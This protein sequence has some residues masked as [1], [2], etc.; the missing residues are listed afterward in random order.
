MNKMLLAAAAAT[1]MLASAAYAAVTF[2]AATGK[3]FVGK[4]DVQLALTMNNAQLQGAANSIALNDFAAVSTSSIDSEWICSKVNNAGFEQTQERSRSITT[5]REGLLA[6]VARERNQIT[7]FILTGYNGAP[8]TSTHTDGPA[9]G[10]CP[11]FW[12]AS[13]VTDTEVEGTSTL[14]VRGIPLN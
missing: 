7:G 11:T 3:G 10:S 9:R 6:A 5:K 1:T 13:E 12:T 14:T 2:D 4:G 8:V